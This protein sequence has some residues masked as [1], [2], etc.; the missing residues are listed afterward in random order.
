[1]DRNWRRQ[2]IMTLKENTEACISR[3]GVP[4]KSYDNDKAAIS[5]DIIVN[6]KNSELKTKLVAYK[7]TNCKKYHLMS[8]RK[9]S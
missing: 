8:V 2:F 6:S 7:C 5:A 1:M 9:K 4:K 3:S